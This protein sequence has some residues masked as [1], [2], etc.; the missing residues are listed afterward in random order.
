MI[1]R[2]RPAGLALFFIM[3]GSI[4]SA[5]WKVLLLDFIIAIVVTVAHGTVFH[6]KVTLTT[7][8]FTLIGLALAI[9]L[10][11]RNSAAYDRYWES[12]KL[13]G[14]LVAC[15]RDLTRQCQSMI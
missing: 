8:P 5:I 3:R 7:I 13:W 4:L 15:S 9:F 10:G 1:I 11:F 14:R 2:D 6:E 12:R